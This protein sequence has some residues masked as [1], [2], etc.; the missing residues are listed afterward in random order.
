M[1]CIEQQYRRV[2]VVLMGLFFSNGITHASQKL[3]FT[4]GYGLSPIQR[5]NID[6][7]EVEVLID[8]LNTP[9]DITV[10][11]SGQKM[12]W[13]LFWGGQIG[14]ANLDGSDMEIIVITGQDSVWA[15][16]VDN[17]AGKVYWT[18]P[19]GGAVRRANLDGSNIEDV[20]TG[21]N[22]PVGLVLDLG[23]GKVYWAEE[24]TSKIQR[25][26]L[27][28][29][30]R[31]DVLV[32]GAYW[33]LTDIQLDLDHNRVYW[34]ESVS[35]KIGRGYLDGSSMEYVVQ[36]AGDSYGLALDV[37]NNTMYW[38]TYEGNIKRAT[39]GGYDVQIVVGGF[40]AGN[41]WG[42]AYIPEPCTIVL[43]AAG[44][45]MARSRPRRRG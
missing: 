16:E 35:N 40:G 31:E 4:G 11:L 24:G 41:A 34:T 43:L 20:A 10:D 19:Y 7:T 33:N 37:E 26:D 1:S 27:D 15:V 2:L 39:L 17:Q 23:G 12:Y 32:T 38:A 6:G 45:L 30:N 8:G 28:G 5:C 36:D 13:G 44:G 18:D 42:V 9:S 25:A 3:Y 14:R 22:S 29:T 21:V